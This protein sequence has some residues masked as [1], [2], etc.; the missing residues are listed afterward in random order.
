MCFVVFSSYR[1]SFS[2]FCNDNIRVSTLHVRIILVY[3][4]VLSFF[5]PI[6]RD[7]HNVKMIIYVCVSCFH[8]RLPVFALYSTYIRFE[9]PAPVPFYLQ[10]LRMRLV[11]KE[12]MRVRS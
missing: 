10:Y 7:C 6:G 11:Q 2:Q 1:P 5:R 4:C 9:F 3:L 8:S 12:K